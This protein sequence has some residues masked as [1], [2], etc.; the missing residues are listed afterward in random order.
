MN[1]ITDEKRAAVEAHYAAYRD[2]DAMLVD[3]QRRLA[4]VDERLEVPVY[5]RNNKSGVYHRAD[6]I[7]PRED[8]KRITPCG[9]KYHSSR[10]TKEREVPTDCSHRLV[11]SRCLSDLRRQLSCE[12]YRCSSSN[13]SSSSSSSNS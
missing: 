2:H 5:V 4:L 7:S 10:S 3:L 8:S 12:R 11:R 9:W 6:T 1:A 13:S